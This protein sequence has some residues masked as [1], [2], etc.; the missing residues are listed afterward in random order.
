VADGG[1]LADINGFTRAEADNFFLRWYGPNNAVLAIV[2]DVQPAEVVRLVEK[3]FGPIPAGPA[4]P[5]AAAAPLPRPPAS[6]KR[7][8]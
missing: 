5:R 6:P 7:A 4:V 8:T 3:Y 2:G 1:I